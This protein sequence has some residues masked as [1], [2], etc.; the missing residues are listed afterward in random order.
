MGR[1]RKVID[2]E[3]LKDLLKSGIKK[4]AIAKLFNVQRPTLDR[5]LRD[6]DLL[7][8]TIATSISDSALDSLVGRENGHRLRQV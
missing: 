3:R 8:F 7:E 2:I 6:N 4:S 1:P 5:I